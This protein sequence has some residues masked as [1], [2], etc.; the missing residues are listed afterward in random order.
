[1]TSPISITTLAALASAGVL[2]TVQLV[3]QVGGYTV[4]VRVGQTEKQLTGQRGEPRVFAS[5]DTAATQLL[6]LGVT[7]FEVLPAN[8]VRAPKVYRR[9]RPA[10]LK[11]LAK[12]Q[13]EGK[14]AKPKSARKPAGAA[15][16][17]TVAAKILPS[18]RAQLKLPG[19]PRTRKAAR[20]VG[21]GA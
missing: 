11:A 15:T 19:L 9:G 4:M 7:V 1:M 10:A 2:R 3:G 14:P 21:A 6:A 20:T 8:Y 16:V 18:D 5:L 12:L 17:A 13:R